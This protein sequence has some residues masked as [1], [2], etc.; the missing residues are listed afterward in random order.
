M[1]GFGRRE[2][3]KCMRRRRKKLGLQALRR[4]G[5]LQHIETSRKMK[6]GLKTKSSRK[7]KRDKKT[8]SDKKIEAGRIL[9]ATPGT[10]QERAK[11]LL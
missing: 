4:I 9:V 8:K 2:M 3:T 6:T 11:S 1:E 7:T 5:N 10:T